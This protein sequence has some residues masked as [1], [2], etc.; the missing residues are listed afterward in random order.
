[1]SHS[2]LQALIGRC[3]FQQ[4]MGLALRSIEADGIHLMVPWRDEFLSSPEA[5]SCHGGILASLLD[6]AGCYAVAAQLGY[7]VP[8]VDMR[9]DYHRVAHPDALVAQ[10]KRLKVGRTIASA[11]ARVFDADDRLIASGRMV[12]LC[13]KNSG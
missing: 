2:D 7:S 12:Y 5:N 10:A 11:E 1:M 6:A 13:R 4:W 9:V 8:T 3:P